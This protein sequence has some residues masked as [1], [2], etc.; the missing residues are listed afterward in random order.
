MHLHCCQEW[1]SLLS[2]VVMQPEEIRLRLSKE[3]H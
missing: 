1:C 2:S 3:N